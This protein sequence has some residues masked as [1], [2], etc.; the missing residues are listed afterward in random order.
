MKKSFLCFILIA[1]CGFAAPKLAKTKIA[2]GITV[3]LPTDWQPMDNLDFSER[4]PSVRKP[5]AAYTNAERLVD[6]SAN[7]SATQWPDTDI[8]L[9]KGFFKSS[10]MNMFDKVEIIA[11]GIRESHGKKYIYFEF[12]SRMNGSRKEEG[13]REPVLRYS[14]IQY[15]L[16]PDR[17]LVFSF[18]CPTR[19]QQ[20]WQETARKMMTSIRVK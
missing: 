9:A 10:I 14:Y 5:L 11:E 18:N 7:I 4:Y 8:E 17:T 2:N 6:F 20:D 15:L 1:L 13:Q 16:E 12:S 19:Q 3:L